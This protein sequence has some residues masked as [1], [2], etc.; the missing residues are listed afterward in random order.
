LKSKR[1]NLR[2]RPENPAKPCRHTP[3]AK[4]PI[5]YGFPACRQA[6][7]YQVNMDFLR[8]SRAVLAKKTSNLPRF[9]DKIARKANSLVANQDSA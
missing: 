2:E 6:G 3:F 9:S 8:N 5:L 4:I 7:V 1:I